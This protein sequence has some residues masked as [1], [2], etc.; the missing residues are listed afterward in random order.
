M[1]WPVL[2]HR[3]T[4]NI[5][6]HIKGEEEIFFCL[7]YTHTQK[8]FFV[9][10]LVDFFLANFICL[11]E[12]YVRQFFFSVCCFSLTSKGFFLYLILKVRE[13]FRAFFGGWDAKRL[14]FVIVK[15][16]RIASTF[17]CRLK[18]GLDLEFTKKNLWKS[19]LKIENF[20]RIFPIIRTTGTTQFFLQLI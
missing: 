19:I 16:R 10:L 14:F 12:L 2:N 17:A 9:Q 13:F 11:T 6:S 5:Q 15:I 20:S 8:W 3:K 7:F 18:V 1:I 4:L